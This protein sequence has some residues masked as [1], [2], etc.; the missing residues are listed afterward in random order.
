MVGLAIKTNANAVAYATYEIIFNCDICERALTILIK[1][2]PLKPP[3]EITSKVENI[4]IN[5]NVIRALKVSIP[6][7]L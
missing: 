6:S 4:L 7:G 5:L 2:G 3:R 1:E